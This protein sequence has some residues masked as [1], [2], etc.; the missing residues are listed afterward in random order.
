M[1]GKPGDRLNVPQSFD[2]W[3]LVNAPSIPRAELL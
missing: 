1:A 2:E 3:K